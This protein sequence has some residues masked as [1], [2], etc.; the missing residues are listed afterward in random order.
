MSDTVDIVFF[1]AHPDD[2]ELSAGGTA[3]KLVK[4]GLRIGLVDLT[5]GEMG[6]RGTPQTR[7]RE[8]ANAAK[9]LG[10]T[11]RQ[12]LDFGDGNLQYGREQELEIIAILRQRRPKL[13]VAPYPDDRHPDHTRTGRLITDAWFYAGLGALKTDLPA[14]RPQMVLYYLQNYMI[15]PSFVV[16]VTAS[17]KTKMRAVLAYR[18][19][20]HDPKSKEPQTFISDPKFL[21]MIDA[22]GKHFGALIGAAYGEA[23]VTKQ[24]PRVDDLIGAY[25]G[26]E[27]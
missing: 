7:R 14:H 21:E 19:Q 16:D 9:A 11:F 22:R 15:P 12:Q 4:D 25:A 1:G 17:W 13:V 2:I 10:A 6:T 27:V 18:S 24:P 8:A 26:R 20:F 5:R 3:A 23:F